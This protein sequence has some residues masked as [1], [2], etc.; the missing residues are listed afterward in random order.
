MRGW[1][2]IIQGRRRA[3]FPLFTPLCRVIYDGGSYT[4]IAGYTKD[5]SIKLILNSDIETLILQLKDT[6]A[7]VKYFR[8]LPTAFG[9]F[10]NANIEKPNSSGIY[11]IFGTRLAVVLQPD[12]AYNFDNG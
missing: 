4:I 5:S 11:R 10:K 7:E 8:L 12:I 3:A 9:K 1:R 6:F 2:G